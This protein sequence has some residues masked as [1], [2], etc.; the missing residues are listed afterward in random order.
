MTV[1][2]DEIRT[3]ARTILH[4][5]QAFTQSGAGAV[6]R[7]GDAK[8]GETVSITDFGAVGNG[9]ADDTLAIQA[10]LAAHDALYF[11]KGTYKVSS[12][13]T[14]TRSGVSW[15]GDGAGLSI[16]MNVGTGVTVKVDSGGGVN[17]S[18]LNVTLRGLRLQGQTGTSH[19]LVLYDANNCHLDDVECL[20]HGGDGFRLELSK[21]CVVVG[22]RFTDNTGVGVRFVRTTKNGVPFSSN[23]NNFVGVSIQGNDGG[24]AQIEDCDGNRFFGGDIENNLVRGLAILGGSINTVEGVWFEANAMPHLLVA[25]SGGGGGLT[26]R[27][28]VV[29]SSFIT[30][31]PTDLVVDIQAGTGMYLADNDVNGALTIGAS[32]QRTILMPQGTIDGTLTD[33]GQGTINHHDAGTEIYWKS[34]TAKR[35]RMQATASGALIGSESGNNLLDLIGVRSIAGGGTDTRKNLRGFVDISEG[36]STAAVT[37]GT[38]EPDTS[39]FVYLSVR[40]LS[41]APAAGSKTPSWNTPA[42]TG[43]TVALDAAPGAGASVRVSWFLV[44]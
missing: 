42:T 22:G 36:T 3:I 2:R 7:T 9:T 38:A 1:S 27:N 23:A 11:P 20:N 32:A 10:A 5:D 24:G 16:L 34:G 28:R 33:N 19:G 13:L 43:F 44:G 41:G 26:L 12:P 15:H 25:A 35:L 14:I 39:Y 4:S 21:L 29:Y 18:L 17:P 6:S 37:F 30:P 40:T 8:M 31:T